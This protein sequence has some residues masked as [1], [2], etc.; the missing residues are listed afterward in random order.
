M[1]FLI[2]GILISIIYQG[3]DKG[4][5]TWEVITKTASTPRNAG[6]YDDVILEI[7]GSRGTSRQ[8]TITEDLDRGKTQTFTFTDVK[9]LGI[10]QSLYVEI[11]DDDG[12]LFE[13]IIVKN[14]A[15]NDEY[16]FQYND[17]LDGDGE[18]SVL[19]TLAAGK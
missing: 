15:T 16:T 6:S 8:L 5:D 1:S 3:T 7:R 4:N 17:W 2:I 11:L 12:W 13:Q 10:V 19:L 9:D 18:S 14:T